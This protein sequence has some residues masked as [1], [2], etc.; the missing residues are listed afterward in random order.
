MSNQ[1]A[2]W[3]SLNDEETLTPHKRL[4]LTQDQHYT[5]V[6]WIFASL[7][8][9][10]NWKYKQYNNLTVDRRKNAAGLSF[11]MCLVIN[12]AYVF[13]HTAKHL[14]LKDPYTLFQFCY[15][16]DKVYH[17]V[18]IGTYKRKFHWSMSTCEITSFNCAHTIINLFLC[19]YQASVLYYWC[20]TYRVQFL[21]FL[22]P[23]I[24]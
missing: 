10:N 5:H 14:I 8:P 3:S 15:R 21:S 24:T 11:P 6:Q 18:R 7:Y 9:S 16:I 12:T 23:S 20:V 17:G 2:Y 13:L 19:H 1:S 4:Y 22:F